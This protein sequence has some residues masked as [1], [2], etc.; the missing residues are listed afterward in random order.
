MHTEM[1]FYKIWSAI[2]YA[3]TYGI[4]LPLFVVWF[5]YIMVNAFWVRKPKAEPMAEVQPDESEQGRG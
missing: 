5:C 4:I 3:L 2:S 1:T